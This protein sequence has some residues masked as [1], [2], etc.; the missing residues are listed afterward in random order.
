M[1]HQLIYFL[2]KSLQVKYIIFSPIYRCCCAQS[3]SPIQL[4]AVLWTVA[5]QIRLSKEFFRQEYWSGSPFPPPGN[6][7]NPVIKLTSLCLLQ[8][9][10][11]SLPLHHLESPTIQMSA[12]KIKNL[13]RRSGH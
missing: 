12:W 3:L 11:D 13:S 4:F 7:P 1:L 9:Q 6:L 10:A 2:A 5:H 8:W